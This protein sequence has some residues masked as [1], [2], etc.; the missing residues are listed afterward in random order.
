MTTELTQRIW[1]MIRDTYVDNLYT[2]DDGTVVC[3]ENWER[4]ALKGIDGIVGE[5]EAKAALGALIGQCNEY[6]G[7]PAFL[8]YKGEWYLLYDWALW[9]N[10]PRFPT[11]GAALTTLF[12]EAAD[13]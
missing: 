1:D 5:L 13:A 6:D 4:D 10:T 12:D 8:P 2:R 7:L 3:E 9:P 11:L